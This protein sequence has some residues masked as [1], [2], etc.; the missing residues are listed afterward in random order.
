MNVSRETFYDRVP[1]CDRA[2]GLLLPG[3]N[4]AK[5]ELPPRRECRQLWHDGLLDLMPQ[6]T[7]IVAIGRYAQDYHFARAGHPLPKGATLAEIVGDWQN[8][9]RLNPRIIALPHPS[10]GATTPGSRRNPVVYGRGSA[11]VAGRSLLRA[12]TQSQ[13]RFSLAFSLLISRQRQRNQ[14]DENTPATP[15]AVEK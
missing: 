7:C 6:L 12:A 3:L 15:Q 11:T 9:K 14:H 5:A 13:M 8:H 1:D 10:P 4:A 2:D